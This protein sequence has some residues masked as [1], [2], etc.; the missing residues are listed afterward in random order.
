MVEGQFRCDGFPVA[1]TKFYSRSSLEGFREAGDLI[2]FH[3][4]MIHR[5]AL[6]SLANDPRCMFFI[7]FQ[8]TD[9]PHGV[10]SADQQ[11]YPGPGFVG[12]SECFE[13]YIEELV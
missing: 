5:G 6:H 12:A 8:Y 13:V 3:S 10:Y 1:W 9:Q 11:I 2:V 4:W 7:Q